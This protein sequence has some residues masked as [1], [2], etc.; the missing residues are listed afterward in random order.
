MLRIQRR[1]ADSMQAEIQ[2]AIQRESPKIGR[3]IRD[4]R[5]LPL[6]A[7]DLERLSV[8]TTHERDFLDRV[9][10]RVLTAEERREV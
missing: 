7:A 8:G 3:Y 2:G 9:S 1:P 4:F 5:R 6:A 10:R